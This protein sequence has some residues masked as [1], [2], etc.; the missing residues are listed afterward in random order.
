MSQGYPRGPVL[1]TIVSVSSLAFYLLLKLSIHPLS[2][3]HIEAIFISIFLGGI[4]FRPWQYKNDLAVRLI[5]LAIIL[6][7][8][9]LFIN[10]IFDRQNATE[11]FAA[12]Q[13]IKLLGFTA[14]GFWIG[15]RLRHIYVF[16][17]VASLGL[18]VALFNYD[19]DIVL[20]FNKIFRAERVD[21]TNF[22][23]QHTA[24]IFG[25]AI[26]ALMSFSRDIF[27]R[28]ATK[29]LKVLHALI[30][31]SALVLVSI[32]FIGAQTRSS[33]VAMWVLLGVAIIHFAIGVIKKVGSKY[34]RSIFFIIITLSSAILLST[35]NNL[36]DKRGG[37]EGDMIGRFAGGDVT[38]TSMTTFGIRVNLWKVAGEW[39]KQ[40]PLH[41]W[42][43]DVRTEVIKQSDLPSRV[44]RLNHFHNSYVDF[45]LSY[46][47]FGLGF[48]VFIFLWVNRRMYLLSKQ[49]P[50]LKGV[51]FFTFYGSI[52]F[53]IVNITESYLLFG[54]GLYAM[55][56]LLAPAYS[57]HLSS[58][59]SRHVARMNNKKLDITIID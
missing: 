23:I 28:K 33:L 57:L 59:Y 38:G 46:G 29:P 8:V 16:L 49:N 52:Y 17:V 15:G 58:V 3:A 53:M 14:L 55:A 51:W 35:T 56:V 39:I 10:F 13:L 43:G 25:L 9:F 40:K 42:G 18:I 47:L 19:A 30:Y 26:I 32:V 27:T 7:L 5:G 4:F 48:I 37:S 50:S 31:V 34:F 24:L 11:Y 6:P 20:A 41:G 54:T 45:A 36:L 1:L 2:D 44:K 12:D 22:N 21:F